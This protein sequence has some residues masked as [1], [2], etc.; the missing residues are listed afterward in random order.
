MTP[1]DTLTLLFQAAQD[2]DEQA[3]ARLVR[4]TQPTI[5]RIVASFRLSHVHEDLVQEIYLKVWLNR[6]AY[7]GE[8]TVNAWIAGIARNTAIDS[9]R[10][11]ARSRKLR[12]ALELSYTDIE[13]R[14]ELSPEYR[15]LLS[16]TSAENAEA[17]M[18]TQF[19][20]LSYDEAAHVLQ[21]PVGT[22]R[23]RIARA[24]T[25]LLCAYQEAQTS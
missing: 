1:N 11:S 23:S 25:A 19:V 8:A 17:F 4:L 7:R 3:F 15:D 14:V 16:A 5:W 13:T 18:L 20:G 24:R 12:R 6:H 9:I 22:I 2:G 10:K 21:C